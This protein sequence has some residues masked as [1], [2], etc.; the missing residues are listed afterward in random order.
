MYLSYY[1]L[2]K[3]P[4]HITP[5]PEF[6]F[7][8][9]SH[10]E[11]LGSLIYGIEKR[12]GFI[13]ITGGVGLG[14]TTIVRSYL[15]AKNDGRIRIVYIFNASITFKEVLKT[16]LQELNIENQ[17]E[18]VFGMINRLYLALIREYEGGNNVVVIIDEAQNMPIETLENLRMLSNLE[19]A[20]D[21]LM[22]IVFVGQQEFDALLDRQELRQLKQRIAIR[23]RIDPLTR[24]ESREYIDHRLKLAGL[25]EG[26]VLT[27][28]AMERII[29]EARGVPRTINI[30]CDNALITGFG[31]E[32]KPVG[33][34]VVTEVISDFKGARPRLILWSSL[35]GVAAIAALCTAFF[36]SPSG[37]V[38]IK[39]VHE[40]P[41]LGSIKPEPIRVPVKSGFNGSDLRSH[42]Q[43]VETTG[44]SEIQQPTA[45][46]SQGAAS[47]R[48]PASAT[49]QSDRLGETKAVVERPRHKRARHNPQSSYDASAVKRGQID[50]DAGRSPY[51]RGDARV[52]PPPAD[53]SKDI[54]N[55]LLEIIRRD[56]PGVNQG[57]DG[58]P[59]PKVG[60]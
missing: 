49:V 28:P 15:D 39:R 26:P 44:P 7:L 1:S 48:S 36:L 8:N 55:R 14:K 40:S 16:I 47:D 9:Q 17:D 25:R 52:P 57:V 50:D 19:T 20:S 30:L 18:D 13:A 41:F 42:G 38:L 4:F 56:E 35:S 58:R 45:R 22:Q 53:V 59:S 21:K 31:Y 24:R 3:E 23:T 11:A 51:K 6:L 60:E 5:D 43:P 46:M 33:L 2:Q 27:L 32:Q 10:K 54:D 12:K 34:R 37:N 29:R